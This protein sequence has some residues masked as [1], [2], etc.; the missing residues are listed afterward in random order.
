MEATLWDRTW[1]ILPSTD[2]GKVKLKEGLIVPSQT[3]WL[4]SSGLLGY[5]DTKLPLQ[6]TASL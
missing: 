4:H 3:C 2:Y 6:P 1:T 5:L